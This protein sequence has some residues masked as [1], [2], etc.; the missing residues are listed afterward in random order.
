MGVSE[1]TAILIGELAARHGLTVEA[2]R[3][4][5]AQGLL[6]PRRDR[7]GRRVFDREQ[8]ETLGVVLALRDAGLGIRAIA[9]V[10]S[11]K[12]PGTTARERLDAA[13]DQLATLRAEVDV[14]RAR[15]DR[16]AALLASWEDD[17][18][19]ARATL[20]GH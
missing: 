5:E 3:Y 13:V 19:R 16:A 12:R 11:L 9:S 17:A 4:Y 15:L 20:D 14:R 6:S 1:A 10:V 2:V 8:Q 18:R 7:S